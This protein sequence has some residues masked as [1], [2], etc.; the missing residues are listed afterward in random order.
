MLSDE[1]DRASHC[2]ASCAL[3]A[4]YFYLA[5]S[6]AGN[7]AP[8]RALTV[9]DP[10]ML[11]GVD[12]RGRAEREH[13]GA[14]TAANH[15]ADA[16]VAHTGEPCVQPATKWRHPMPSRHRNV[17]SQVSDRKSE[18]FVTR[19]S[20]C[21]MDLAIA[22]PSTRANFVFLSHFCARRTSAI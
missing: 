8:S 16:M 13:C 7:A 21:D 10:S 22:S 14:S 18:S 5:T 9:H 17:P 6:F 12:A 4:C 19:I 1:R 2:R 20:G 11:A 3:R 15:A